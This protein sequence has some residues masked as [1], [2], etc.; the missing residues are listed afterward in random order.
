MSEQKMRHYSQ[1]NAEC[2]SV[3][4]VAVVKAMLSV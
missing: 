2:L 4:S 1:G 3:I